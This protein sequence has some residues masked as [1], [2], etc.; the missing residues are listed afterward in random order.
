MH[1]IN[2]GLAEVTMIEM[3]DRCSLKIGNV[4]VLDFVGKG[5]DM[6]A[7]CKGKK[8]DPVQADPRVIVQILT[9][10]VERLSTQ[11]V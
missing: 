8:R 9:S 5:P 2:G 1:V 7:E 3:E 6:V 10:L 11:A 4:R